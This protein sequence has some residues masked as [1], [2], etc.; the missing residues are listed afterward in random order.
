MPIMTYNSLFF[1]LFFAAFLLIYLL[2]PKSFL[3]QGVILVGNVFFYKFAGGLNCMALLVAASLLL[4]FC[5]IRIERIYEGFEKEAEGLSKK[6]QVPLLAAYKSRTRKWLLLGILLLIGTLVYVKVGRLLHF[7][8]TSRLLDIRFTR[9]MVPL[10]L[11]YYTFSAVG[12]L[13]DVYWRKVKVEHN[14]F[15]L[16]TCMTFFPIIVQ[17]PISHYDRLAKQ[18]HQLPGFSYERVCHGMQRMWWGFLKKSIIADRIT[19]VTS[20]IFADIYHYAGLEVV[21]AVIGNVIAIYMDFSG[22]MDIVIGA[23][24]AMGITLDENFRQPF[25][26]KSAAEFWRRWHITLGAWF[27]DYVYMPIAMNPGFMKR[28]AAIRKKR[29]ARAAQVFSAAVPLMIVWILTGLWHGTGKDYLFWGIYWGVLIIIETA[30]AKEL[31]AVPAKLHIRTESFGYRL[32][33]MI[34]TC[35]YFAIGRMITACGAGRSLFLIIGQIFA[36]GRLHILRDGGIFSYGI[37]KKNMLVLIVFFLIVWIVDIMSAHFD[38]RDRIDRLP[39]PL[40]W[41]IYYGVVLSVIIFGI[42]GNAY[43]AGAFAYGGF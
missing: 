26:A 5:S 29:G 3:K 19:P 18:F 16:L 11:S 35:I 2:M 24:E 23:A 20:A 37:D 40:R 10:G 9:I 7:E 43:H 36:A 4:Y 21:L 34:R 8:E 28:T 31:K 27:K 33:Q 15:T 14:Y 42:Y 41:V 17:G 13:A 6:E 1:V 30:F 38:V 12:Y 39:F 25:F 22:C 32:F